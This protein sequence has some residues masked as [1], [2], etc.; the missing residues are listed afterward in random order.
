M[1]KN[2][3]IK[4]NLS[5]TTHFSFACTLASAF[6]EGARNTQF[7]K[8]MLEHDEQKQELEK[9][10]EKTKAENPKMTTK[11]LQVQ[12]LKEQQLKLKKR[13][14][15]LMDIVFSKMK[16]KQLLVDENKHNIY[17]LV[18]CMTKYHRRRAPYFL[19]FFSFLFQVVAAIYVILSVAPMEG[20]LEEWDWEAVKRNWPLALCVFCY[21]AM[22]A[23]PEI[24]STM[25]VFSTFYGT[26]R[27]LPEEAGTTK[28]FSIDGSW[29]LLACMD[30]IVNLI[31][32][33]ILP[34]FGFVVVRTRNHLMFHTH[35]LVKHF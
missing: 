30:A 5:L 7:S 25:E 31:L 17:R 33:V 13:L 12:V 22:V 28:V 6:S 24:R 8:C 20:G 23:L 1:V 27:L 9:M 19:A 2:A 18:R 35:L 15:Q 21:G 16:Q 4:K 29:R 11:E 10:H 34:F 14:L 3:N 32:P 26:R